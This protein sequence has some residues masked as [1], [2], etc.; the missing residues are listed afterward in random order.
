MGVRRVDEGF[1]VDPDDAT[2]ENFGK[3]K[4]AFAA[5]L[6]AAAF[7]RDKAAIQAGRLKTALNL[8]RDTK[9]S[10]SPDPTCDQDWSTIF[11]GDNL[12]ALVK[13]AISFLSNEQY[14]FQF[15][16]SWVKAARSI[17][18][19]ALANLTITLEAVQTALKEYASSKV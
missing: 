9:A 13:D 14:A 4:T 1:I 7:P 12:A 2:T 3:A 11:E 6:A 19:G 8:V 15:L 17:S 16:E 18:Q 10:E 5:A